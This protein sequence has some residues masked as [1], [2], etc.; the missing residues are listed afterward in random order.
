MG[1]KINRLKVSLTIDKGI[2]NAL[3]QIADKDKISRSEATNK[4]LKRDEQVKTYIEKRK[5]TDEEIA[6]VCHESLN[7]YC[8]AKGDPT[9]KPWNELDEK[10]IQITVSGVT[11]IRKDPTITAKQHFEN[12]KNKK[13][14][15]GWIYGKIKDRDKKEHPNIIDYEKLP[16]DQR[17]KDILFIN[18]VRAMS[19]R[20][21]DS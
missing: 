4:I 5:F 20:I 7:A 10:T 19:E 8:K 3:D 1:D 18:I 16:E 13:I 9:Y 6:M 17:T 14:K 15:Q 2:I 11:D 21:K 12:W